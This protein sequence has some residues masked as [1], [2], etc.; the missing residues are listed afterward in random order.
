MG[1][2]ARHPVPVNEAARRQQLTGKGQ[3]PHR[4]HRP[5]SASK[6]PLAELRAARRQLCGPC[7]SRARWG[8]LFLAPQGKTQEMDS[9][10]TT[11]WSFTAAWGV[12]KTYRLD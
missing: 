10:S 2:P 3:A 8:P 4:H 12:N 7:G 6:G 9:E 1:T 5:V 11:K